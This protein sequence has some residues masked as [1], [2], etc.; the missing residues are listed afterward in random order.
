MTDNLPQ[1][2]EVQE[3]TPQPGSESD[4]AIEQ[5]LDELFSDDNSD[6]EKEK[7]LEQINKIEKRN[8]KSIEDY[9][10]T[11]KERQKA[12][13]EQGR[14]KVEEPKNQPVI[15]DRYAEK[16]LKLEN[17][18]SQYVMDELKQVAK[19]RGIDILE[20]WDKFSWIRKEADSKAEEAEEQEKNG[21]KIS[22]PTAKISGK[23]K[24][25]GELSEADRALLSRRPGLMEKYLK[26]N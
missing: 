23:S 20:A 19:E 17:P 8:Y 7:F 4:S 25:G 26:S 13:S 15:G 22:K 18:K 16:L 2:E 12:F 11:V 10:K 5:E 1:E 24:G 14:K 9:V 3:T 21:K 6:S